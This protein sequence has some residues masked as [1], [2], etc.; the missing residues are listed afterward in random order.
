[1]KTKSGCRPLAAQKCVRVHTSGSS[2]TASGTSARSSS[3][4]ANGKR[5]QGQMTYGSALT[6]AR[7]VQKHALEAAT[8]TKPSGKALP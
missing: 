3:A 7:A 8:G 6:F 1:M 5:Y 4:L 2:G